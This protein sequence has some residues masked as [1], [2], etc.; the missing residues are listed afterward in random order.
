[1]GEVVLPEKVRKSLMDKVTFDLHL[2]ECRVS[3]A[4]KKGGHSKEREHYIGVLEEGITLLV[5]R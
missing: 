3:Q 2:E 4:E 1:M 5:W